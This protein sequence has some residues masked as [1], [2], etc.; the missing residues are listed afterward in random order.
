MYSL[1]VSITDTTTDND[2]DTGIASVISYAVDGWGRPRITHSADGG[3]G[4]NGVAG[5]RY[6]VLF[7]IAAG[8]V[9]VGW[10][11]TLR[12][13][14]QD[15]Q[16]AG[17]TLS[18]LGCVFLLGVVACEIVA[19]LPYRRSFPEIHQTF[20]FGPSP[21]LAGGACVLGAVTWAAQ[22]RAQRTVVA[23]DGDV[24][25]PPPA[26]PSPEPGQPHDQNG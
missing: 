22:F 23:A 5:P 8:L 4:S 25:V 6:G 1:T 11:L 14:R 9:L 19:T 7:G 17:R 24:A 3:F 18:G 20:H 26:E 21:W 15:R 2:V 16:P 12:A 10:L 13:P